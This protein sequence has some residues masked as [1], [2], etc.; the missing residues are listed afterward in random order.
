MELFRRVLALKKPLAVFLLNAGPL[1]VSAIKSSGVPI[2]A[3]G[4]GGEMGGQATADVLV[5][6]YSPGGATTTTWYPHAFTAVASF[7]DMSMRPNKTIGSP[8]RTY[9]FLD[10][11][12]VEPLWPFGYGL[13]FTSFALDFVQTP[14]PTTPVAPGEATQWVAKLTNTGSAEGGIAVACYVSATAV[15]AVSDPPRRSLFDFARS[16]ELPP[17]A[18]EYLLFTLS[19]KGRSL[20]DE[21]GRVLQPAGQYSVVCEAAGV[22][23]TAKVGLRVGS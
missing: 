7:R 5:G 14:S 10:P 11:S 3:A 13:S 15:S 4:Y 17:G 22:A 18:S 8:G 20:V 6:D 9:R 12:L 23:T 21:A 1:D 16:A 19:A 2:L